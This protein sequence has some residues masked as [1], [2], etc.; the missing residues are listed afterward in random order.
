MSVA[1]NYLSSHSA[2]EQVAQEAEAFG[3]RVTLVRAD[4]SQ[5]AD[6]TTMVEHVVDQFDRIDCLV[7]NAGIGEPTDLAHI[8]EDHFDNV[9]RNNLRSAFLV[10][11]G[12]LPHMTAY[13]GRL[14]FMSSL[15][16]RTGGMVSAAYAASKGGLEGLMHYY[17][18]NLMRDGITANAIAP[19]LISTDM[20]DR[21]NHPAAADLPLGR[22]GQPEEI[23]PALRMIMESPYITG[24]TIHVNAG[25]YMT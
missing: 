25:M 15:A 13:G 18:T 16:A 10:T 7:N 4:C 14:V 24:Q 21:M 12:V 9:I 23:W 8:T 2:A 20:V 3:G 19:A 1:I 22:L 6:V 11:Q 5:P 17:A